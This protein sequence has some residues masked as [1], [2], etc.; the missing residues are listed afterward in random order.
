MSRTIGAGDDLRQV[1]PELVART[2]GYIG[3]KVGLVI[4]HKPEEDEL[5]ALSPLWVAG[6]ALEAE[7]YRFAT[8]GDS[9]AASGVLVGLHLCAQ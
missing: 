2:A 3:A 7:G 1:L 5:V 9:T 6:Q 8:D 4:L